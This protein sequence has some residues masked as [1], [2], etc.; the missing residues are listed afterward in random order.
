MIRSKVNVDVLR[1]AI[2]RL[3]YDLDEPFP[4]TEDDLVSV[5]VVAALSHTST[6]DAED[7]TAKRIAAWLRENAN[8]PSDVVDTGAIWTSAAF[9]R[10]AD[11]IERGEW[12]KP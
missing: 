1:D 4:K 5:C 10:V 11:A 8:P 6:A 3:A 9:I 7:A 2:E 12:R